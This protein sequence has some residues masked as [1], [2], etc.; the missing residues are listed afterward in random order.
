MARREFDPLTVFESLKQQN[1]TTNRPTFRHPVPSHLCPIDVRYEVVYATAAV[2]AFLS[3]EM[4]MTL[5]RSLGLTRIGNED[6]RVVV[7][8]VL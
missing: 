1:Q 5:L 7:G 2:D 8:P 3:N 6:N 4:A